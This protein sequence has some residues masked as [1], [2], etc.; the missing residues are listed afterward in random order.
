MDREK[1]PAMLLPECVEGTKSMK[2]ANISYPKT[3]H[4]SNLTSCLSPLESP[5]VSGAITSSC[6]LLVQPRLQE[7]VLGTPLPLLGLLSS[8]DSTTDKFFLFMTGWGHNFEECS[9]RFVFP[10]NE[11]QLLVTIKTK[12]RLV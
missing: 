11:L 7:G 8:P 2:E 12:I 3:P 6:M 5:G 4:E 9:G 10:D 1:G